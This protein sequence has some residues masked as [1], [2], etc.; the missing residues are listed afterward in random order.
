MANSGSISKN[1]GAH[2]RL[3][4]SWSAKQDVSAN[5]STITAKMYW[6]SRTAWGVVN[7]SATKSGYITIDGTKYSFSGAGLADLSGGQKRLIATKSRTISHGSDGSKRFSLTGSFSPAVTL[8]GSYV[9]TVNLST[10]S[11]DLNSIP[12]KSSISSGLN[13][14]AGQ[15]K[16]I[17]ISRASSNFSHRLY[18][19]IK[20]SS[21]SWV[22][23]KRFDPNSS[24]TS[25][26]TSFSTDEYKTIFTALNQ[27]SSCELR[28][29]LHTYNGST[30]IGLTTQSGTM[31]MP[32][33]STIN[34]MTGQ[35]GG[36]RDV[37]VDQTISIGIRRSLSSFDH[38]V[39]YTV[40]SFRKE[41]N[42]VGT[43]HSW[44][45][46]ASEQSTIYGQ[47]GSAMS[48]DGNVEL[49]TFYNGVQ[50]G[51]TNNDINFYV[52]ASSSAPTFSATGLRYADINA[53]TKALTGNDQYIVQN[54]SQLRVTIPAASRATAKNGAS[55]S[56]YEVTV[57]G[58]SKTANYSSSADVNIDFGIV[59]ANVNTSITVR[60]VDNR[61]LSASVRLNV[62]I[63]PYSNPM[64]TAAANRN[65]G[66]ESG[67]VL[68]VRGTMSAVKVGT[69]NKNSL[70][71]ARYR[72]KDAAV[73]T[74]GSWA[75]LSVSGFP[76]Y[77]A[78][79]VNLNL[80]AMA[81]WN[82]QVE[83]TDKFGTTTR[84]LTVS[85][86]RP[87]LFLDK[88][89]KSV[90]I[91]D[92]PDGEYQLKIN[93]QIVFGSTQWA[94]DVG[95][96]ASGAMF[97]N[98]SDITGLN[99]LWFNDV[100]NN[101]GEGL[102]FLKNSAKTGSKDNADYD[103]FSIYNGDYKHNDMKF[104]NITDWDANGNG[105][106]MGSGG[107]MV[108]GAGESPYTLK[109]ATPD[110]PGAEILHLTTDRAAYIH[111]AMQNGYSSKKTW[112][113]EES[114]NFRTPAKV[115]AGGDIILESG[116]FGSPQLGS[117]TQVMN[118]TKD[119]L[120]V[121]NPAVQVKIEATGVNFFMG[122]PSDSG[123]V[124]CTAIY[125]TKY[126]GDANMYITSYGT[127]GYTSS[128]RRYKLEIE[129]ASEGKDEGY[130]ER[131]LDI[132]PRSWF[133]KNSV[134]SLADYLTMKEQGLEPDLDEMDVPYL[135]RVYGLIAEEV[136]AAGLSEFVVYGNPDE[137]GNR[138]VESVAYSRLWTLLIPVVRRLR[139]KIVQQDL[140]AAE[141]DKKIADQAVKLQALDKKLTD[142]AT[143]LAVNLNTG[144]LNLGIKL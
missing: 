88:D 83:I 56:N 28:Y 60:A 111:T 39:V 103:T 20:N 46:S 138:A 135:E 127:L 90:G 91:G 118:P 100:A 136:E 117:N 33:F 94:T 131:I 116:I 29:N 129:D 108:V 82:I 86:G 19:D 68:S 144:I 58:I 6:E 21:G 106:Y 27:R 32:D 48:R 49:Y 25:F 61:G 62:N 114:G 12:R 70:T 2:W 105:M 65:N 67:T 122:G 133:D 45:P 92:F 73:T 5:K 81:T 47:I 125:D 37:Y 79:N 85:V 9:G 30:N 35:A 142:L 42:G 52:S 89:K 4:I 130:V 71:T 53:A 14:D 134:E 17:S 23:I 84:D 126:T 16:T 112:T 101:K 77:T 13:M 80:D 34:S 51:R 110:D 102:L 75:N 69:A 143:N 11:W 115:Y 59:N 74:W 3:S 98:N 78:S 18:I 139:D 109:D 43:G 1:V 22:N 121:G 124:W 104:M 36:D 120:F 8:D 54:K 10:Q 41:F 113:F 57:N 132:E 107:L 31:F 123:R 44:T 63:I 72:Y 140:R 50:V 66:F 137:N 141:Q 96:G 93:G 7:S 76:T 40:G 119:K 64:I 97:L 15:N 26:S 95:E 24:T 99:G 55:I 128:A 87:I 38:R